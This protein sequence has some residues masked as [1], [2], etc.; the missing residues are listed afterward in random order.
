[1]SQLTAVDTTF[2]HVESGRTVA[3]IGGLGI[4]D[5]A[6]CPGGALTREAVVELVRQRAHLARPLRRKLSAAP[7]GIDRPY[8]IEDPDFDPS[9]HVHEV[10]LPAPG[11]DL[12]LGEAIARLH[13]RPLDR[14]RPL[15]ELYLVQGLNG[16]RAALFA[17]VHHAASDGVLGAELLTALLDVDPEPKPVRAVGR[18]PESEEPERPPNPLRMLG[19]GLAKAAIHPLHTARSIAR[20]APYLDQIPVV[21]QYPGADLMA[22]AAHTVLRRDSPPRL[23]RL[24]PPRTPFDGPIGARRSFAFGSVPLSDIRRLRRALGVSVN[25]IVMATCATALRRWLLKRDVLP[26]QPLVAAVPV[27][28]RR[29]GPGC[30]GANRLSA[31][32]APL[33]THIADPAERFAAVHTA[34]GTVKRRFVT[35]S[36]GDWFEELSGMVPGA[37]SAMATRVALQVAPAFVQPANLMISNVPG[38]QVPL[39]ICGARVLAYYPASVI[40]DLTGGV[41]ITVF[42]YNGSLDIGIVACPDLVPGNW[43]LIDYM[44]DGLE[45]LKILADALPQA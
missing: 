42:S 35:T 37:F 22:R 20:T 13:E 5:P 32:I 23:P 16:G 14:R 34:M 11:T 18:P 41:N 38:P 10:G 7:L 29:G 43:D 33:P 17:K 44:R 27:S 39:Y 19:L 1:M 26:G 28:L 6:E 25:D 30:D 36:A 40:S 4:V 24:T 21:G 8:W 45:E 12:Q 9:W 2:L 31:M 15:W 3:H